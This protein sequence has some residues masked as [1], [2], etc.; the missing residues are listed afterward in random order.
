MTDT[1]PNIFVIVSHDIGRHLGC[2]GVPQAGT[3]HLDRF[4]AEGVRFDRFYSTSPQCGPARASLF[5]GRFPHSHGVIGI[6]AP[7]FDF[8][9][10]PEERHLSH[11][12]H[13]CGY[14]TALAGFQHETLRL[15][16]LPFE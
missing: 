13:D 10:H 9:L 12:L 4:A 5:T 14:D 3:P 16:D 2:Y 11:L 1:R 7:T 8:D 15:H 6:C